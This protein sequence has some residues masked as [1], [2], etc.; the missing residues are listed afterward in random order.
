V[1]FPHRNKKP[2][3]RT[4]PSVVNAA[5]QSEDSPSNVY[6]KLVSQPSHLSAVLAPQNVKQL[7]NAQQSQRQASRLSHDP[8]YNLFELAYDSSG[9]VHKI[10]SYP[11]LVVV[12][13][14]QCLMDELNRIIAAK[15]EFTNLLPY[16]TTF[17]LGNIYV[18]SFLFRHVIFESWP[19]IPAA[20]LLLEWKFESTHE[21][22]MDFIKDKLTS[23]DNL[24]PA[25]PIAIDDEKAIDTTLSGVVRLS[26]WNHIINSAKLWLRRHGKKNLMKFQYLRE[27]FHQ[28]TYQNYCTNLRV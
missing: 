7:K 18:S 21:I 16:D 25:V 9:F 24:K 10:E 17:R 14:L 15:L 19:V 6:R 26:C 20:F 4:C 5:K 3:V 12:C 27:F 11:D 2:F 1:P 13:E 8:V 22:F 28:S 23:L